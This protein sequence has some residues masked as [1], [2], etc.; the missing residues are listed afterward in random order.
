MD[1]EKSELAK[2]VDAEQANA[3]LLRINR[4]YFKQIE[5][6]HMRLMQAQG[7]IALLKKEIK[8]DR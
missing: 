1:I 4:E 3:N 7:E 6:L 8:G 2:R 5:D